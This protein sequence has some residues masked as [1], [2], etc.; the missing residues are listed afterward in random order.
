MARILVVDDEANLRHTLGYALRQEGYEVVDAEDGQSGIDAVARARPDLVILDVML[1]R[2]D[3][4]EVAR[5]IRRDS[6]VPII[7]L[8]ARDSELDKVVGL[9]IGADDHLSKPFSVRELIARVRALLRRSARREPAPPA[10]G[11][12]E[13][14]GLVVDT[15]RRRVTRDGVEVA[16][17][18]REF[19]LLA[20]LAAHP[21][22]VF[23]RERILEG[24]WRSDVSRDLR[25]VD[26][27]VKG[28][29]A[30]LADDPARPRWIETVRGVGY[31]VRE[32]RTS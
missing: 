21:G 6:E 7:L 3:G 14:D 2:V 28:L 4:L 13:A 26:T 29:R 19:D 16:L 12:Y 17:K 10:E 24:A 27:Q 30:K 11:V 20:F 18:P 22:H 15:G 23:T 31:R 5:R 1:P 32:P 25:S 9:E 8:T